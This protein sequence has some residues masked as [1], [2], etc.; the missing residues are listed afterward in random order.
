MKRRAIPDD[1]DRARNLAQQNLEKADHRL[2]VRRTGANVQ[3]SSSVERDA[4]ESRK[5]IPCQFHFQ[6]RCFPSWCPGGDGHGKERKTRFLYPQEG[7][8]LCFCF[9]VISGQCSFCHCS[10][11]SSLRWVA[12]STGF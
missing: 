11:A 1:Q 9:F 4:A 12:R 3:E 10:I 7:V 6:K 2:G 5:M 8:F